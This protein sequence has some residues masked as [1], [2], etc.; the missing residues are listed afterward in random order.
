MYN[1]CAI[2]I[3][4]IVTT[5]VNLHRSINPADC[6]AQTFTIVENPHLHQT[7]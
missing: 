7:M 6:Q 1:C 4:L 3:I 5:V 2:I